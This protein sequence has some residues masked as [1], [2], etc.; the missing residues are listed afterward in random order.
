MAFP[1]GH[2]GPRLSGRSHLFPRFFVTTSA[3]VRPSGTRLPCASFPARPS[4]IPFHTCAF[5]H[6]QPCPS[7]VCRRSLVF[8]ASSRSCLLDS[9]GILRSGPD[10]QLRCIRRAPLPAFVFLLF[11]FFFNRFVASLSRRRCEGGFWGLVPFPPFSR[12]FLTGARFSA[13]VLPPLSVCLRAFCHPP[14]PVQRFR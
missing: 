6:R 12:P 13:S 10:I 8:G 1:P 7:G 9:S 11:F 4:P 2:S 14:P 3:P 5:Q